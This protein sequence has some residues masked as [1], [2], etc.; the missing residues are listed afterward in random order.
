MIAVDK[1]LKKCNKCRT[2]LREAY[3]DK[4]Y[5]RY[6]NK[7]KHI[8][9]GLKVAELE[10][11]NLKNEVKGLTNKN[12]KIKFADVYNKQYLSYFQSQNKDYNKVRARQEAF[13]NYFEGYY[14]QDIKKI[15]VEGYI[16]HLRDKDFKQSTLNRYLR[17]VTNFFNFCEQMELIDKSPAKYIKTN[18]EE[19]SEKYILSPIDEDNLLRV[20][21][22]SKSSYLYYYVL[23]AIETGMRSSEI[24][25]LK[26]QDVSFD[27]ETIY[28][29]E[30]KTGDNRIIPMTER[31][32]AS[33]TE[34]FDLTG[35]T[36]HLF[37]NHKTGSHITD[38]KPSF[39]RAVKKLGLNISFHNLRHYFITRASQ[40]GLSSLE[41]MQLSGHKDHKTLQRYSHLHIEQAQN[42]MKAIENYKKKLEAKK[43]DDK[44]VNLS[45]VKKG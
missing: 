23:I 11:S 13:Y 26:W 30:T 31:L 32:R 7:W 19:Q 37:H 34:L 8:P 27:Y 22:E 39:T 20:C 16:N 41:I 18:K 10:M 24:L 29:T 35:V 5:I 2:N 6:K 17:V 1:K 12:D 38:L 14:L 36:P 4:I 43:A 40:A 15:D 3:Q 42:S 44:V 45:N 33:L 28:V 25:R 21:R 9:E